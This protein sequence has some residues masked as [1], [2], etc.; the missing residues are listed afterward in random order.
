MPTN[1]AAMSTA[2]IDREIAERLWAD[3]PMIAVPLRCTLPPPFCSDYNLAHAAW[4]RLT[5]V[6]KK[7]VSDLAR[8]W[9]GQDW[10][11]DYATGTTV[12][13]DATPRQL[14]EWILEATEEK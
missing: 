3:A 9:A 10:V 14:C 5:P 8:D 6:Q 2:E 4:M 1:Y 11:D 12:A 13:L 7:I